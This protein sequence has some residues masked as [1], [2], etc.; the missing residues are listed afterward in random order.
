MKAKWFISGFQDRDLPFN[1]DCS[2][3]YFLLILAELVG[4]LSLLPG[5]DLAA[6]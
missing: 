6:G 2:D 3:P 4:Q 1:S 5:K